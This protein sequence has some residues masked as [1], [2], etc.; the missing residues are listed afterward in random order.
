MFGEMGSKSNTMV[1]SDRCAALPT[2]GLTHLLRPVPPSQQASGCERPA[3]ASR[4]R[5]QH[6]P[7]GGAA[8]HGVS[9]WAFFPRITRPS[10]LLVELGDGAEPPSSS[11]RCL[12]SRPLRNC[13]R[14]LREG[15]GVGVPALEECAVVVDTRW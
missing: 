9:R 13:L 15:F 5:V 12:I 11:S 7:Q 2:R 6:H 14:G 8:G 4:G 3:R 10:P 1:F